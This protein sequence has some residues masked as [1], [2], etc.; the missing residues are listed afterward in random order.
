MCILV[1]VR[2]NR[3]RDYGRGGGVYVAGLGKDVYVYG[4]LWRMNHLRC[5]GY[6]YTL[7]DCHSNSHV[8]LFSV[9]TSDHP[10]GETMIVYMSVCACVN[11]MSRRQHRDSSLGRLSSGPDFGVICSCCH[12]NTTQGVVWLL[13]S[14]AFDMV[15]DNLLHIAV[16]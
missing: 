13:Y 8:L 15:D 5:Y 7:D 14:A 6:V 9:L 3:S 2:L 1:R 4:R 11:N 12:N 16:R 10:P